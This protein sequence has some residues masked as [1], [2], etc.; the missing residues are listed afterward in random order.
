[1]EFIGIIQ[2]ISYPENKTK[3]VVEVDERVSPEL[4]SRYTHGSAPKIGLEFFDNRKISAEQ[5][6]KA[7]ALIT[8]I[9]RHF[10][11][12]NYSQELRLA[13][14][15][16]KE[17]KKLVELALKE[18]FAAS[19]NID[20]YSLANS[21]MTTARDFINYLIE[22]CFKND[23]PF[24]EKERFLGE[25]IQFFLYMCLK[26]RKCA[27]TGKPGS[28]VHHIDAVGMGRNRNKVDSTQFRFICLSREMHNLVHEIGWNKFS[29]MH[30]VG[31]IKLN[32]KGLKECR[33]KTQPVSGFYIDIDE[34]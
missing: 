23:V 10:Y 14:P 16:F 17:D 27:I 30:K 18:T 6:G 11:N 22:F 15:S 28:D 1:M 5:R 29:S 24:Y 31:A 3:F 9:T 26:Y 21:D 12:A 34:N 19:K 20:E 8:E 4:I 33:I 2:S 25:D 7:F 32:E 13:S